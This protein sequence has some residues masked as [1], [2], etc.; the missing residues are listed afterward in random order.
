MAAHSS[1]P[2]PN[3]EPLETHFSS[4][5]GCPQ[6]R[7]ERGWVRMGGTWAHGFEETLA[8]LPVHTRSLSLSRSHMCTHVHTFSRSHVC[9]HVPRVPPISPCGRSWVATSWVSTD[10]RGRRVARWLDLCSLPAPNPGWG[11][12]FPLA[13][14]TSLLLFYGIW[15]RRDLSGG[16]LSTA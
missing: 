10:W 4:P 14:V 2:P 5:W 15:G 11:S 8:R 16:G 9:A 7:P 3:P 12:A 6:A 1:P 13:L